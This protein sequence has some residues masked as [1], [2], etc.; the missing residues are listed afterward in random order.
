[1]RAEWSISRSFSI[2]KFFMRLSVVWTLLVED[3]TA[4]GTSPQSEA[5]ALS[6]PCPP[7]GVG[8]EPENF[9]TNEGPSTPARN[10]VFHNKVST[11]V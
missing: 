7:G 6:S 10:V 3:F 1:M 8:Q 5:I 2:F 4:S 9:L 11:Y